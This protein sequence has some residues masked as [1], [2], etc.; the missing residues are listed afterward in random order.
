MVTVQPTTSIFWAPANPTAGH[1]MLFRP[2]VFWLVGFLWLIVS[3]V[4]GAVLLLGM[5]TGWSPPSGLRLV[6]V[7]A[8]L[9]GG[10]A[11]IMLGAILAFISPL[12][13]TGGS[14]STSHPVLFAAMNGGALGM[15]AGFA[16]RDYLLVG[17][18]G[19]IILLVFASVFAD[20]VRS[21]RASLISPP[22]N[23]WFYGIA[24]AALFFG[25]GIGEAI[26]LRW[27]PLTGIGQGR[28][29]HIHL[30]LL[31]FVTLTIVGT[32]HQ[33]F[34]TV[35]NRPLHSP[36]LA[37]WT[38]WLFPGGIGLL[39]AGFTL[40][41]VVL[42]IC[43]GFVLLAGSGLYGYNMLRTWSGAVDSRS[44]ASDHLLMATF[45]LV[46]SIV[47]G[48]LVAINVLWT[49]PAVPFGTLHLVAYT[50]LA[51]VGF[52]L[53]T[54]MGALSHLL[55]ITLAAGRVKS[56]KKRAPYFAE[57]TALVERWRTVQIGA[58][59]VGTMGLTLLAALVWQLPLTSPMVQA[60][61]WLSIGLLLFSLA[62]FSV[63]LLLL[64]FRQPAES[65]S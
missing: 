11:Q 57:L 41:H 56:N 43:A 19:S 54:I 6:H 64:F 30:N 49:P 32:M 28:L 24:L 21:S 5:T 50:H 27:W 20:V 38:F 17:I 12:L 65:L 58:L 7:H 29:A 10:V 60:A 33:L 46:M 55:P 48:L 39:V 16:A 3:A 34:P 23:I 53:Q 37:R 44:T 61:T 52:I 35:L 36:R 45:F 31:G 2:P 4:L 13:T 14:R 51:L 42:Q 18:A 63:K 62:L 9:V 22:L 25:L 15:V 47:A 59:S 26:A 1:A 40:S 8:A